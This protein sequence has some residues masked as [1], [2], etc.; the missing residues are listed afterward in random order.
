MNQRLFQT[1]E[2]LS[3]YLEAFEELGRA[4][5]YRS[6]LNSFKVPDWMYAD[7]KAREE[8]DREYQATDAE[9]QAKSS[10]CE[11]LRQK[12]DAALRRARMLREIRNQLEVPK[13]ED[14]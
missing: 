1:Y 5:G 6:A 3:E 2:E 9:I 10:L 11:E 12:Y 8:L 7:M 14:G 13:P 4:L